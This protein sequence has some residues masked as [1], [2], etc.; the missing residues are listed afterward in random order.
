MRRCDIEKIL[1]AG[2]ITEAQCQQIIEH[3][4]LKEDGNRFVTILSWV[5]AILVGCGIILL[6]GSNWEAIPRGVKIAVGLGLMLGAHA[7]GWYLRE[8]EGTYRKTGEALHLVGSGLFLGNIGLIGQIYNLSSRPPN[9]ILLWWVGIAALP[10]LLRSKVQHLLVLCAFSLWFGMEI[11]QPGS[12][13]YFGEDERQLVVYALLGLLFLGS[14]YCL[15]R[16]AFSEFAGVTEKL[17]LLGFLGF[18]YPLTWGV[19]YRHTATTAFCSWLFPVMAAAVL[20]AVALDLGPDAGRR[21]RFV[22]WRPVL[23][24]AL[25]LVFQPAS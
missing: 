9:A 18:A 24:A 7:G 16:T 11:N 10:W 17:G 19:L 14:G 4:K 15:R 20:L 2:L 22:G 1:Q 13:I 23:G 21:R 6:I 3:F 8:V 5:G 25:D 12:W